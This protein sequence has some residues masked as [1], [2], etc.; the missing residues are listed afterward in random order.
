MPTELSAEEV[1]GLKK[2]FKRCGD[3]M[4]EAIIAFRRT[5]DGTT[6]PVI[7]HG[8][9]RRYLR[10]ETRAFLDQAPPETPLASLGVDSLTMLEI[11]LDVQEALNIYIEDS[12]LKVMQTIGDVNRFLAEKT[13]LPSQP[14]V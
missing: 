12:D 4:I 5:G 1:D 9:I 14:A 7:V 10:E 3:E 8:I 2:T 11:A 13:A 6:I